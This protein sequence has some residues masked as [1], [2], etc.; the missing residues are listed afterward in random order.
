MNKTMML[1]AL[2]LAA[3]GLAQA[4]ADSKP[5]VASA[6]EIKAPT[7]APAVASPE[8][9][10]RVSRLKAGIERKLKRGPKG[11][12]SAETGRFQAIWKEQADHSDLERFD[13]PQQAQ[14]HFLAKRLPVGQ[15]SIGP[16]M[17][18]AA[19]AHAEKMPTRG[20][21]GRKKALGAGVASRAAVASG[22]WKAAG[23]GNIGGR[24]RALLIHP[25]QPNTMWAAGVAGGIWKSTD[26]GNT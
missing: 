21:A 23:P 16:D 24:T 12:R 2:A 10:V 7:D 26:G 18:R 9:E 5:A 11:K 1:S 6:T 4:S 14:T 8:Q 13:E 3:A 15:M 22:A 20:E 19:L 17:Y 25:T